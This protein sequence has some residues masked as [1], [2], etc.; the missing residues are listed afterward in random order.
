MTALKFDKD[1]SLVVHLADVTVDFVQE[2]SDLVKLYV[3]VKRG[4]TTHLAQWTLSMD[5][6]RKF[7][8]R[9]EIHH[10]RGMSSTCGNI[11]VTDIIEQLYI[12]LKGE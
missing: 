5:N 9:K 7:G 8:L 11:K 2:Y 12:T 3:T 4:T 10:A 6:L 1:Y